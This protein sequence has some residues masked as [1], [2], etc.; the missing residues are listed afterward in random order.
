MKKNIG[1]GVGD[2]GRKIQ[3]STK[4]A[5]FC[6]LV[7]EGHSQTSAYRIA[8]QHP[9]MSP[10]MAG[11]RGWRVA[12]QVGVKHLLA[13]LRKESKRKMLLSI[14]DRLEILAEK[15][16][17]PTEKTSDRI[18]AIEAYSKISGDMAPDRHEIA[19]PNGGPVAVTALVGQMTRREKLEQLKARRTPQ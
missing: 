3:L 8:Y 2:M 17:S 18:R 6:D 12:Q 4:A 19:G 15:A 13:E 7:M 10:E 1:D 14:N 16:Q 5:R 9:K 11:E